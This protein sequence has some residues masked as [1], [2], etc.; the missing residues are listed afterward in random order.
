V[1]ALGGAF[2]TS[3]VETMFRAPADP[4]PLGAR[5]RLDGLTIEVERLL[6]GQPW[7]LRLRFA[8]PVDHPEHVFLSSSSRGLVRFE[9]PPIGHSERLTRAVAPHWL[10]LR[11]A[12]D[13]RHTWPRPGFLQFDPAPAFVE[14]DPQS[15]E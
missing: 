1:H 6:D 11:H 3:G 4:I 10:S 13:E 7:Q 9:P 14:Y 8:L 12:R 15:A 5:I 2:T